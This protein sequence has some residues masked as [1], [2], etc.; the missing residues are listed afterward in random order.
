MNPIPQIGQRK[1]EKLHKQVAES[2]KSTIVV[3]LS[4]P[5]LTSMTAKAF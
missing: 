2:M 5:Q 4:L 3:P 1:Q